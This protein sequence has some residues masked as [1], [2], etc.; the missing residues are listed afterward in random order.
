VPR[1]RFNEITGKNGVQ[2]DD[3]ELRGLH[4]RKPGKTLSQ[5]D[6][7]TQRPKLCDS[8]SKAH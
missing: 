7:N 1:T 8:L 5:T 4:L 6:M 2:A 3:G